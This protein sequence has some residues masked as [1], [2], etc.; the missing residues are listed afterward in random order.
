MDPAQLRAEEH[1][2]VSLPFHPGTFHKNVFREFAR[3]DSVISPAPSIPGM[4]VKQPVGVLRETRSGQ[5]LLGRN[6]NR[7]KSPNTLELFFS[8]QGWAGAHGPSP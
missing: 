1:R 6:R 8:R 4:S 3:L 5:S 2:V 7:S